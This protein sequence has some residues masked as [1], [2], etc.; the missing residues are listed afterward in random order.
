M[1]ISKNSKRARLLASNYQIMTSSL[2]TTKREDGKIR[3]GTITMPKES[4]NRMMKIAK[5]RRTN[6]PTKRT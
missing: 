5:M 4:F 2:S 1:S 3:L 6:S